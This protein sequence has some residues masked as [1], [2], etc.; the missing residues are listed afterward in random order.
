MRD[1]ADI[2]P[3]R[4]ITSASVSTPA[5]LA[6]LCT[7]ASKT[8]PAVWRPESALCGPC[9]RAVG[10]AASASGLGEQ[11]I[12]EAGD[13]ASPAVG[14]PDERGKRADPLAWLSVCDDQRGEQFQ[15]ALGLL[16]AES[17]DEQPQAFPRCHMPTVTRDAGPCRRER[18]SWT[19][20]ALTS[21]SGVALVAVTGSRQ[22]G[23]TSVPESLPPP[24][25]PRLAGLH[26]MHLKHSLHS[27]EGRRRYGDS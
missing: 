7:V 12:D 20:S 5:E 25:G 22:T 24:P 19:D 27:A 21:I 6:D 16:L 23:A 2:T 3:I 13:V 9:P 8:R 17:G 15:G 18:S 10:K 1:P 4:V 26:I 14:D 11:V